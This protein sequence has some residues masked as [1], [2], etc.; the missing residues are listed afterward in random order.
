[1]FRRDPIKVLR[2]EAKLRA[3]LTFDRSRRKR[4]VKNDLMLWNGR[5]MVRLKVFVKKFSRFLVR[6][7]FRA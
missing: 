1:M 3:I 2:K 6:A 4:S 7:K 5:S